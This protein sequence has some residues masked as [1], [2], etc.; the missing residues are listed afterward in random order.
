ML[1]GPIGH[2][3]FKTIPSMGEVA[4]SPNTQKQTQRIRKNDEAE[5]CIQMKTKANLKKQTKKTLPW[6]KDKSFS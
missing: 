5:E 6:I 4:L 2:V 3:L 1:L